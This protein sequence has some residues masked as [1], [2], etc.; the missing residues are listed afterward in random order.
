MASEKWQKMN[1]LFHAALEQEADERSLFLQKACGEDEV[2][3]KEVKKFISAHEEAD[4]FIQKPAFSEAL[5]LLSD[6]TE[7]TDLTGKS[8]NHYEIISRIGAGGMGEVYLAKDTKL[9]RNVALKVLLPEITKDDDRVRR[10]KLEARAVS[11][12]NH[13]NIITIFEIGE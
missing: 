1:E 11:T 10:F 2:L 12:L 5:Q 8:L 4:D 13:P 6:Q 9:T 7:K 3:L